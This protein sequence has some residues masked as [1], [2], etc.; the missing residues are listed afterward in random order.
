MILISGLQE[1]EKD[2][3]DMSDTVFSLMQTQ[4]DKEWSA[5]LKNGYIR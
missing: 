3:E 1:I 4:N 5:L 2:A